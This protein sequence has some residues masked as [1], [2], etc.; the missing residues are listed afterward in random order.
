LSS[1]TDKVG[2]ATGSVADKIGAGVQKATPVMQSVADA[3]S[4]AAG[5]LSGIGI[6]V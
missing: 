4:K 1:F 2:T 6:K 3:S 5:A